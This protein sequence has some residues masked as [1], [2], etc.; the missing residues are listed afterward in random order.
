MPYVMLLPAHSRIQ[1]HVTISEQINESNAHWEAYRSEQMM[2]GC[3]SRE[4]TKKSN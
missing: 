4:S 3:L 1:R 2:K